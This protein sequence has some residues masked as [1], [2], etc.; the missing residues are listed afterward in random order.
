MLA[1]GLMS[2]TSLDG[3][4]AAL[5]DIIENGKEVN[6]KLVNYILLPYDQK[7]KEKI[8]RNLSDE[9]AEEVEIQVKYEGYIKLQ[10]G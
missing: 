9:T 10:E 6:F 2:G 5:V 4:D 3:V 7:F 8:M 1:I